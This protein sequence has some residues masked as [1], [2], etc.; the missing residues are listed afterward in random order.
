MSGIYEQTEI[1][2]VGRSANRLTSNPRELAFSVAWK[3]Q[4][5]HS[6]ALQWLL[7]M[8]DGQKCQERDLTQHEATAA[9]TVIQWLG[10]P[11]GRLWLEDT[12]GI[13]DAAEFAI[14]RHGSQKYGDEPYAVHLQNVYEVVECFRIADSVIHRAAWLQDVLEDTETEYSELLKA[15]GEDVAKLVVAVTNEPGAN[16]KER[17]VR[18]YHKIRYFGIRAVTL[19]LADRIANTEYSAAHKSPQ[20]KMYCREFPAFSTALYQSGEC[21]SM[22]DHLRKI[23][24]PGA[25]R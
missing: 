2:H 14:Q 11:V 22:W 9:A 13:A 17:A 6:R 23:S 20:F 10:S 4:Q 15:F 1:Q 18:T 5:R 3:L 8:A 25:S 24:N 7:C 21:D 19:K 16:R 12:L